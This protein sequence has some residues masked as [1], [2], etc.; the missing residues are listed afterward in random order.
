ML[1]MVVD[2]QCSM[3]VVAISGNN[4]RSSGDHLDDRRM[5]QQSLA[6][7]TMKMTVGDDGGVGDSG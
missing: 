3:V 7:L 6:I 5:A 1:M 4:V 2:L